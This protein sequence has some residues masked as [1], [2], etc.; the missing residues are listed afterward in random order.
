M[1]IT[2]TNSNTIAGLSGTANN[3]GSV[4]LTVTKKQVTLSPTD[5][6]SIIT[7]P[8]ADLLNKIASANTNSWQLSETSSM[9]MRPKTITF[10]AEGLKPN[11]IYYPFFDGVYVG[12]YCSSESGSKSSTLKTN[13]IG[14]LTGNFYLPA[15]TFLTGSHKF[16][17]VDR[18]DIN[19]ITNVVTPNTQY[20][21][22]DAD[23]TASGTLKQLT[24]IITKRVVVVTP[25][26]APPV[27]TVV[28]TTKHLDANNGKG[29]KFIQPTKPIDPVIQAPAPKRC[30]RWEYT[31]TIKKPN[32]STANYKV[33]WIGEV[34]TLPPTAVRPTGLD[35][36]SIWT[37]K[38]AWA[39]EKA[40]IACPLD[41]TNTLTTKRIDPLAQSFY[42]DGVTY[43]NGIFVTSISVYF[44]VVDQ[45]TPV[46]LELRNMVNGS[47]GSQIMPSGKAVVP[48]YACGASADASVP[49]TFVF[50]QP[51]YLQPNDE[52]CFVV[53]STSL[54][55]E[56]WC[57]RFGDTDVATGTL[58]E[59]QP[60]DGVLFKS[61]ND[62]TWTPDQY[63]D[64]TFDVNIAAFDIN[65][66]GKLTFRPQKHAITA[67]NFVVGH[68]YKI[69]VAGTTV[70]TSIG[71]SNNNVGTTF[72]ATGTGSGTGTAYDLTDVTK[73]YYYA[74]K[75]VL[76]LS[77]MKST[78]SSGVVELT[79]P[80]H[81]LKNNDRIL[82]D[83]VSDALTFDTLNGLTYS[84]L[85]GEFTVTYINEDKVSITAKN[86][87]TATSTGN[88]VSSDVSNNIDV[89]PAILHDYPTYTAA[90]ATSNS[91]NNS[92]STIPTTPIN[93]GVPNPPS[94]TSLYTFTVYT[95]LI[96]D[97]VLIDYLGAELDGTSI[98][99]KLSMA[100]GYA[101]ASPIAF[102]GTYN[103]RTYEELQNDGRFYT[104]DKPR[105]LATPRNE[106]LHNTELGNKTSVTTT[107]DLASTDVY[108]S[109]VVDVDGMSLMTRTH[110]VDNQNG[111]IDDIFTA[112][113]VTPT[114]GLW[115]DP[116]TNSEL[117]PGAGLAA[118]KYK[119][120]IVQDNKFSDSVM[121]FVT[122]NCPLPPEVGA[123]AGIDAY[124][125]VSSDSTTHEDK[126][127][128]WVPIEGV[129]GKAFINSSNDLV[130]NEW[131][132]EFTSNV[133]FNTYDIKLVMRSTN[134]SVVPKIHGIRTITNIVI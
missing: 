6:S 91:G 95:N 98:V 16:Q 57:S 21:T 39:I 22:A 131:M 68:Q 72:T 109:P 66:T 96:A 19:Q 37:I 53:K 32:G 52:Y 80:M 123:V 117:T 127:W 15:N 24:P 83:N 94:S 118:A 40:N 106:S 47:P 61:A 113:G 1:D 102:D 31:Y 55:Y 124:I 59:S 27:N 111:E 35:T 18:V 89:T 2:T 23:Y 92:P 67:G 28:D 76:P 70:W 46:V 133:P 101:T 60:V 114:A 88:F 50:D 30:N 54:G 17:L 74:N 42:V 126:P 82:I 29:C 7:D 11:T 58:I 33:K 107:L 26:P 14:Q 45:S 43:P 20:S 38:K 75:Q 12:D 121:I 62:S 34:D 86:S 119:S 64:L 99:E 36:N 90:D 132:Y 115:A 48:G 63:E 87:D 56:A 93:P 103:Y 120:R 81:G 128:Q 3:N 49:T 8:S 79:I 10:K 108:V 69:A 84:N 129:L 51:V 78:A 130:I 73:Q 25:P 112:Y 77:F 110:K 5:I 105:L 4:N 134:N 65:T 125:R 122:G 85:M 44:R 104:F 116:N 100:N 13:M 97:E 9:Y 71:A 41:L